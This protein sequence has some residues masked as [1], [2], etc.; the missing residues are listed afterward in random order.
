MDGFAARFRSLPVLEQSLDDDPDQR[1]SEPGV[2]MEQLQEDF[3]R[4]RVQNT[5]GR[6]NTS[7]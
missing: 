3:V 4:D 2:L 1:K 7:A 5:V 6:G